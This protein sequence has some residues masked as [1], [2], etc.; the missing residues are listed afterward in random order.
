M[1]VPTLRRAVAIGST[2]R[3]LVALQHDDI[4]EKLGERPGCRQTAHARADHD[5]LLADHSLRHPDAE[6]P[7]PS[8]QCGHVPSRS[9]L[10]IAKGPSQNKRAIWRMDVR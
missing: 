1:V 2:N 5:G 6:R 3:K 8:R 4:L 7:R 10:R 9:G